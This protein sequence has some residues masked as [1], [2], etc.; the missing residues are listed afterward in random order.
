MKI[1]FGNDHTGVDLKKM[2]MEYLEGKGY[3]CV[4]Y[5]TDS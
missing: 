1:G 3:E 4:N 5:G 2:L